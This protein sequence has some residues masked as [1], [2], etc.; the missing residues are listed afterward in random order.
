M[1]EMIAGELTGVATGPSTM[2]VWV[3]VIGAGRQVR[4]PVAKERR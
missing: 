3:I 4:E 1:A 2:V